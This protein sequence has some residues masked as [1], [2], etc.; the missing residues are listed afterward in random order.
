MIPAINDLVRAPEARFVSVRNGLIWYAID[1]VGDD[2]FQPGWEFPI[3]VADTKGGV[4]NAT[5]KP[6]MLLRWIRQHVMVLHQLEEQKA[7][8]QAL[9]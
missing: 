2:G 6:I 3:P 8:W 7:E 1:Y 4:F 9:Q 5:E